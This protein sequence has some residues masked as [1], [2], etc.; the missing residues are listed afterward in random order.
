[1][2]AMRVGLIEE[3][4]ARGNVGA[5]TAAAKRLLADIQGEYNFETSKPEKKHGHGE[6][7]AKQVFGTDQLMLSSAARP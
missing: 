4:A 3:M 5:A 2:F 1:M 7:S 6:R